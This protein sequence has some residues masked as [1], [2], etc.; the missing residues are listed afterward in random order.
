M[1]SFEDTAREQHQKQGYDQAM[2]DL[3]IE[4]NFRATFEDI[5]NVYIGS[6][7]KLDQQAQAIYDYCTVFHKDSKLL[8][9]LGSLIEN[10]GVHNELPKTKGVLE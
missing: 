9:A 8:S 2:E 5:D 1:H 6:K 7:L 10:I 3:G 4:F